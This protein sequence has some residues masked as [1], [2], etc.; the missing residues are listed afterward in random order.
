MRR[1][2]M[3][4]RTNNTVAHFLYD[5]ANMKGL[6][7]MRKSI[8]SVTEDVKPVPEVTEQHSP[9]PKATTKKLKNPPI[10]DPANV[11]Q[12]GNDTIE[13]KPTKIRYQRDRTAAFYRLLKQMPLV[14]ILALQDGVLDQDRSSD[15]MF[16][17]WL[18]AV[19]DD[20]ALV[21]RNYD[22]LDTETVYK[23]L[24]IFCRLNHIKDDEKKEKA[25]ME[26]A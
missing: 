8:P 16:F 3:G 25:Q 6:K 20:A 17:D 19:T 10:G 2:T 22:K 21:S 24:D 1:K 23:M 7:H 4:Y 9:P 11:V 12:F 15:K 5:A 26:K 13:I 14:D 18:I